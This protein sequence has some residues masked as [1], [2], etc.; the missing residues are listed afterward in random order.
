METHRKSLCPEDLMDRS[1]HSRRP[2]EEGLLPPTQRKE[3][4]EMSGLNGISP[5]LLV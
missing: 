2:K 3:H 4:S 5:F 1:S